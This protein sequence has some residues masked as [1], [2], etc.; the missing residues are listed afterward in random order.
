MAQ[1]SAQNAGFS[2]ELHAAY[3]DA[4][5]RAYPKGL[6]PGAHLRPLAC[7]YSKELEPAYRVLHTRSGAQLVGSTADPDTEDARALLEERPSWGR[8]LLLKP[9]QVGG[10]RRYKQVLRAAEVLESV[11][12]RAAHRPLRTRVVRPAQV[13]CSC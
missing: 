13:P 8:V 12:W 11:E 7:A 4:V 6:P 5:A 3:L 1:P 10:L 2:A 9:E